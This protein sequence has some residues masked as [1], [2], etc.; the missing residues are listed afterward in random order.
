MGGPGF[1]T[2]MV[3]VESG[4][5]GKALACSSVDPVTNPF[6]GICMEVTP[7]P[8]NTVDPIR[9]AMAGL[10]TLKFTVTPVGEGAESAS[11]AFLLEPGLIFTTFGT[12]LTRPP[13]V[14][15]WVT[16]L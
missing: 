5:N 1:P 13:T 10:S 4:I 6:T 14:T 11:R 7:G 9:L 16:V 3:A 2:I 8:K 12:K 15:V